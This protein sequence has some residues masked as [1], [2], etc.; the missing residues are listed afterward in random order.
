MAAGWGFW[1]VCIPLSGE[2]ITLGEQCKE[3]K[4]N[5][6]DE[7]LRS[8]KVGLAQVW[9]K[10]VRKTYRFRVGREA[11]EPVG[12][13]RLIEVRVSCRGVSQEGR[14]SSCSLHPVRSAQLLLH[15][16]SLVGICWMNDYWESTSW[17]TSCSPRGS[18]RESGRIQRYRKPR[19]STGIQQ[20]RLAPHIESR[21]GEN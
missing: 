19:G 12:Q 17:W 21:K 9:K 15:S 14:T 6:Q 7:P 8:W 3:I 10:C 18:D 4:G 1:K 2:V 5:F 11:G 20:T 16:R 13:S